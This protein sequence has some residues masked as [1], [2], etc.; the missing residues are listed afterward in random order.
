MDVHKNARLTFCC[1]VLLVQ[2][3]HCGRAK[4]QVARELGGLGQDRRQV[5]EAISGS[6]P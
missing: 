2:R 6:R 1:R 5:A 4:V 3:I